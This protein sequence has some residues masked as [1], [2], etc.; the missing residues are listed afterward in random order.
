MAAVRRNRRRQ[1]QRCE[2]H[3]A[4]QDQL[5][6]GC[7]T[8]AGINTEEVLRFASLALELFAASPNVKRWFDACQ[9]RPA[10]LEMMRRR[11]AEPA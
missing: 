11:E 10:F 6:G 5:L 7:F 3:L 2:A 1:G 9:A 8:M 4:G